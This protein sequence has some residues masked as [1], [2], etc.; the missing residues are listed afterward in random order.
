[1]VDPER[2]E[3][4]GPDFLASLAF[5]ASQFEIAALAPAAE[6]LPNPKLLDDPLLHD[7]SRQEMLDLAIQKHKEGWVLLRRITATSTPTELIEVMR[8]ISPWASTCPRIPNQ[9]A[10]FYPGLEAILKSSLNMSAIML[11]Q[12]GD[13]AL[14]RKFAWALQPPGGGVD[15][16]T[17]T[18]IRNIVSRYL[19]KYTDITK[20][21][22]SD[23]ALLA[24]PALLLASELTDAGMLS[25]E[26]WFGRCLYHTKLDNAPSAALAIICARLDDHKPITNRRHSPEE[27]LATASKLSDLAIRRA[28]LTS[29]RINIDKIDKVIDSL[30]RS[31]KGADEI[32]II[33]LAN[34]ICAQLQ[35]P[36][37]PEGEAGLPAALDQVLSITRPRDANNLHQMAAMDDMFVRLVGHMLA[38]AEAAQ[39]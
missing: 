25:P 32:P 31:T 27:Y 9:L 12:A 30:Q 8:H 36:Q 7:L 39:T 11:L 16:M 22:S 17:S 33:T 6:S 19:G 2:S 4:L 10:W 14:V 26:F 38:A 29:G 15:T 1:M 5:E 3:D 20:V 37:I 24:Q 23:Q 28:K 21:M 18:K 35:R 34:S 13:K